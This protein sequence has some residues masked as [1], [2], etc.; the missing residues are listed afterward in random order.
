ME[1]LCEECDKP[2][3]PKRLHILPNTKTCINCQESKEAKGKFKKTT[4]YIEHHT[5][6]WEATDEIVIVVKGDGV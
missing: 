4:M 1:V 6:G 5:N 2:I 3:N